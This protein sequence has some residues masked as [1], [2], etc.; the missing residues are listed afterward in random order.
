MKKLFTKVHKGQ[1][2]NSRYTEYSVLDVE[3]NFHLMLGYPAARE[4]A[5]AATQ[6]V[7]AKIQR[8]SIL[9]LASQPP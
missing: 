4:M 3:I 1:T 6:Y 9:D 8:T 2:S 5:P 7:L